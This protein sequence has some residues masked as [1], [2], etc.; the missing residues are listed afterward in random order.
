MMSLGDLLNS[1]SL[2]AIKRAVNKSRWSVF[3]FWI[4]NLWVWKRKRKYLHHINRTVYV[5]CECCHVSFFEPRAT[6]S[7]QLR[8][9]SLR[10]RVFQRNALCTNK[11]L[12]SKQWNLNFLCLKVWR[13]FKIFI[14]IRWSLSFRNAQKYIWNCRIILSSSFLKEIR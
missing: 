7:W 2:A 8:V 4:K 5:H 9:S 12:Q 11:D 3:C 10:T 6:R 1:W 13:N 14:F